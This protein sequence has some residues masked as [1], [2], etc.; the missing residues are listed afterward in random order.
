M[1]PIEL[2]IQQ[3]AIQRQRDLATM[4]QRDSLAP[5]QGQMIGNYYVPPSWTQYLAKTVN[6]LVGSSDQKD[7]D[8]KQ[9]SLARQYNDFQQ[10]LA[11]SLIGGDQAG[12]APQPAAAA[13]APQVG[14]ES[15]AGAGGA[16][17][18]KLGEALQVAGSN[19]YLG[20]GAKTSPDATPATMPSGGAVQTS[21]TGSNQNRTSGNPLFRGVDPTLLAQ[22][23]Q[24]PDSAYG[25]VVQTQM[26]ANA[27]AMEPTDIVKNLRAAGV[28]EGS[29]QWNQAINAAIQKTGYIAPTPIRPG[30]FVQSPNGSMSQVPAVPEGF[31]AVPD[32][33]GG[34]SIA[35]VQGGLAAISA[36]AGAKA[37]GQA[38]FQPEKVWDPA[39]GQYVFTTKANIANAAGGTGG[40][41]G[42]APRYVGQDLLEQLEPSARNAILKSAMDGN[43]KFN[44]NFQ[45][46]NGRRIAGPVD[47]NATAGGPAS[48]GAFAAEPAPGMTAG[49]NVMGESNAK[50]YQA[51]KTQAEGSADRMNALDHIYELANGGTKFGPGTSARLEKLANI[52]SVLPAGM[53]LGNDD[54]K[55]AQIM[56]KYVSNLAGQYMKAL[57]GTGTDAQLSN[58]LKSISNPDMMNDAIKKVVPTLKALDAAVQ[59]KINGY[60]A[61]LA[62]GN[63]VDKGNQ[64][65]A[66]FRNA[67]D[68]RVFQVMQMDPQQRAAYVR[69]M[70][71]SEYANF[72]R[73]YQA[74]KNLNAL[75]Q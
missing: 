30:S 73:K 11:R 51:L 42:Q 28:Q 61:W 58:A 13:P 16:D 68:P 15:A 67:Y 37:G 59:A 48:G 62:Q 7:L 47:L 55:N 1:S 66:M 10:Q 18:R 45:L 24:S 39:S 74:L 32:G 8:N 31:Q 65:E 52:N 60:D 5:A 36:S 64:Y 6:G 49:A 3:Q 17:P 63:T 70:P 9:I 20:G 26:G 43:G 21:T 4:L 27:K 2:Q 72:T 34:W 23:L 53:A 46:P 50:S 29:P 22:F 71:A 75:P 25:K 57:G 14:G 35:P 19:A 38:A 54:T 33:Q 41:P 56:Q 12:A 69:S 40:A 44:L